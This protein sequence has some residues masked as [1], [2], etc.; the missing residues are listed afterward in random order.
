[1]NKGSIYF[2][3][4]MFAIPAWSYFISEFW[5]FKAI[6]LISDTYFLCCMGAWKR[7]VWSALCLA[8]CRRGWEVNCTQRIQSRGFG[9][10]SAELPR[11][12]LAIVSH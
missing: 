9:L 8:L 4:I 6:L 5:T 2:K 11:C 1:M 3:Y 10:T 7:V 12:F